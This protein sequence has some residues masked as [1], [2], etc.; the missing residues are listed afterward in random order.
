MLVSRYLHDCLDMLGIG[1]CEYDAD[2]CALSWNRCF[3]QLFPEHD[4][5]IHCGEP[6]SENL[7]RFYAVQ[8]TPEELPFI[9]RFISEG[10]A[11]HRNQTRPFEFSHRGRRLRA[12]S[13]RAPN[14]GRVR[15][16][17]ALDPAP[18]AGLVAE[19]AQPMLEALRFIPDGAT[20]LDAEDRIIAANA[21]FRQLYDIGEERPIV[22][23]PLDEVIAAC[24][25][26]VSTAAALRAIVRN[27]LRY[28]GAPCEI[29]LPGQRWRR[30]IARRSAEGLGCFIHA[31]ITAAKRQEMAL[32]E[33]QQALRQANAELAQLAQTD[34]LTGLANRRRFMAELEAQAAKGQ[35]LSLLIMD[36]D[37]FKAINDA[38]GHV[39]GDACLQKV[40]RLIE[41]MPAPA[42]RLVARLGGEE[43]GIL[44]PN[45]G[46]EATGALAEAARLILRNAPWHELAPGL[47]GLTVSIGHGHVRGPVDGPAFYACVDAAL[48][49]AK[50]RG[51]DQVACVEA[52]QLLLRAG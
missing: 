41:E 27:L 20:I 2:L 52:S 40:A 10:I 24:W 29:E 13:L 21:A 15:M 14:G 32:M 34:S 31:D 45:I 9:K 12:S 28:D 18:E 47:E 48:Y 39:V 44:L 30:V 43:F 4:G 49:R 33:M 19:D 17:Q 26:D 25:R 50:H 51:R 23:L 1:A 46:G 8:L 16:W 38:F 36:V 5:H 22:G 3:L 6:Y 42:G 37:H 11:R 7:R 35:P